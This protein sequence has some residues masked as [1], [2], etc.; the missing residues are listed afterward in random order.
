[1][2]ICT[3]LVNW[4][5]YNQNFTILIFIGLLEKGPTILKM[6]W[7]FYLLYLFMKLFYSRYDPQEEKNYVRR[8]ML[9]RKSGLVSGFTT[10]R[11][12][13]SECDGIVALHTDGKALQK[14][15]YWFGV[16][17]LKLKKCDVPTP[18]ETQFTLHPQ[19]SSSTYTYMYYR[20]YILFH[21]SKFYWSKRYFNRIMSFSAIIRSIG[22]WPIRLRDFSPYNCAYM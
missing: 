8:K 19:Q 22:L 16:D 15:I 18:R 11:K 13:A 12:C 9:S 5:S 17:L 1:M 10:I 6:S 21:Q 20:P 14:E 2:Y 7:V 4:L 3:V